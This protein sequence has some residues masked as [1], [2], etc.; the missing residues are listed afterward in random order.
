MNNLGY[1][2]SLVDVGTLS[3]A[4]QA[5]SVGES[6][7]IETARLFKR[8]A[9]AFESDN[10]TH[11]LFVPGRV[12]VLGKHTDYAGGRSMT[13]AS[14]QGFA[15]VVRPRVDRQIIVHAVDL[16]EK[17]EFAFDPELVPEVGHWANYPMT[18]ARRLARNFPG[19][20]RGAE[21]AMSA[22]L[23]S[24][25][26]MSTSSAVIVGMFLALDAVNRVSDRPQ[27]RQHINS[28]IDLAG[29]L[30][31]VENGQNFGSL[32]GDCGVGTFGGSEDHTAILCGQ[33]GQISQYSY[34]PVRFERA[35]PIPSTYVFAIA[36]SGVV[37]EKTGSALAK[38][39]AVSGRAA[40]LVELWQQETGRDDPH[41]AAIVD[42]SSDA[43]EQ[44]RQLAQ[45]SNH[46]AF[47]ADSLTR[48]LEQFLD[49]SNHIIPEAADA[50]TASDLEAFGSA[51]DRS[52]QGAERGLE[53]QVPETIFL[54]AAARRLGATAA[55]AFGAGFG[56]SVWALV[57][58]S[59]VDAFLAAWKIAYEEQFA[60]HADFARFFRTT[61]GPAS[62]RLC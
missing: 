38:Y 35:V 18:V 43:A 17:A 50:I 49:E 16:G 6:A 58:Q 60:E 29:Y 41:L 36:A 61:A 28:D 26:G 33:A 21:I 27:Y 23:P 45:Q 14:E 31:T 39:N 53:N 44:L 11:A 30:G 22:N 46:Q 37:A 47:D 54:A 10:E 57:E 55:S 40:A 52:Q 8:A 48:R 34:C 4:L 42:S 32:L 13:I 12:E 19:G 15:F 59:R 9:G 20:L 1:E 25:A 62:F 51:V 2:G 3:R 24:A 7:A 5:A 56:G